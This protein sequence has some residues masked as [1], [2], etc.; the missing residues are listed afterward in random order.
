MNRPDCWEILGINPTRNLDRIRDAFRKKAKIYHPDSSAHYSFLKEKYN[1]IEIKAAE[2]EALKIAQSDSLSTGHEEF[3]VNPVEKTFSKTKFNYL[4]KR[5]SNLSLGKLLQILSV[6]PTLLVCSLILEKI[7]N[8]LE[9]LRELDL[10]ISTILGLIDGIFFGIFG[11]LLFFWLPGL[12]FILLI[13]AGI[14]QKTGY[15]TFI[16]CWLVCLAAYFLGFY[17]PVS[18]L[19]ASEE[20]RR[21]I[22]NF[23]A[24]VIL[25]SFLL[26]GWVFLFQNGGRTEKSQAST[27]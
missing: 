20:I 10:I 7:Q 23:F 14:R 22:G 16:F 1:F 15:L 3:S 24:L 17:Q 6:F 8:S 27:P 9:L 11:S 5:F 19:Q 21:N 25:P 13:W 4:F 26:G 2:N 18:S 12:T